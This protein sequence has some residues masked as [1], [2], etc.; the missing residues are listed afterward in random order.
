MPQGAGLDTEPS[1]LLPPFNES[2]IYSIDG[3]FIRNLTPFPRRD[4]VISRPLP[5]YLLRNDGH[6]LDDLDIALVR[7]RT[8]RVSSAS[9]A[10]LRTVPSD[11]AIRDAIG[12]EM[13]HKAGFIN[14]QLPAVR[15]TASHKRGRAAPP[16]CSSN[17]NPI[18]SLS[19]QS[20]LEAIVS[21]RLFETFLTICLP[22]R[23]KVKHNDPQPHAPQSQDTPKRPTRT[24]RST[25]SRPSS[26]SS[27]SPTRPGFPRPSPSRGRGGAPSSPLH[28][29]SS[30]PSSSS[31]ERDYDE[32]PS[33]IS[34]IHPSSTNPSWTSLIPE[35][36]F[37]P[38]ANLSATRFELTIWG[39]RTSGRRPPPS[40]KGKGRDDYAMEGLSGWD[41]LATWPVDLQRLK[42]F[43]PDSTTEYLPPNSLVFSLG[44]TGKLYLG[45]SSNIT[46][47]R[48]PSP[49]H[50]NVSD[51]EIDA[52]GPT[53]IDP[54]MHHRSR[55][56]DVEPNAGVSSVGGVTVKRGA[57]LADTLKLIDANYSVDVE[58][59]SL[60]NLI[61]TVNFMLAGDSTITKA[62]FFNELHF[63]LDEYMSQKSLIGLGVS[64][65]RSTI[66]RRRKQLDERR[67][68][69]RAA[70][71]ILSSNR[72]L[73]AELD[74]L[75]SQQE[76]RF[77]SQEAT[78]Q[79]KRETVVRSLE[80][81]FPIEPT[82]PSTDLL[83]TIVGVP[84]PIPSNPADPAPPFHIPTRPDVNEDT[85]ASALGYAAQ[86]VS[87]LASYLGHILPYPITCAG[88]RSLIK[89]PISNL[90]GPRMFPLF[91]KSVDMYRFEYAVFLLNKDIEKLMTEHNL[92]ALDMRHTLPN[93]KNLLL[94]L[95]TTTNAGEGDSTLQT[96]MQQTGPSR[97]LRSIQTTAGSI[98]VSN[99][100]PAST[101]YGAESPTP[102]RTFFPPITLPGFW[103]TR[104]ARPVSTFVKSTL[105]A[106]SEDVDIPADVGSDSA[107]VRSL[108]LSKVQTGSAVNH[109]QSSSGELDHV[110]RH[111][112]ELSGVQST[113]TG[114]DASEGATVETEGFPESV[115][116]PLDG[117]ADVVIA[118]ASTHEQESTLESLK[119]QSSNWLTTGLSASVGGFGK[120]LRSGGT[121]GLFGGGSPAK[122]NRRGPGRPPTVPKSGPNS[123]G[124]GNS[125]AKETAIRTDLP[126]MDANL[127][128][129]PTSQ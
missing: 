63:Q 56:N 124:H 108:H 61:D 38:G 45:S 1:S 37:S 27:H 33:F 67:T 127:Q 120:H 81:I 19:T 4:R 14:D 15:P 78:L 73:L 20:D 55:H 96:V 62:R 8:R 46:P 64:E 42:P 57:S 79:A 75:A 87:L 60:C 24:T 104:N 111:P 84:L 90:H 123:N 126:L 2:T 109:G 80:C 17:L 32:I 89:D 77:S 114:P 110:D 49:E 125:Q 98:D 105:P 30:F 26:S 41:P 72:D 36:E 68:N 53:V 54:R 82:S 86:V 51:S 40:A 71:A 122:S 29:S 117:L 97:N 12:E 47:E 103:Q 11:G 48:S 65:T 118:S 112:P 121:R 3:I 28:S 91:S 5:S 6:G 21:S 128:S 119:E 106:M 22:P 58:L 129:I 102:R 35:D 93:L 115:P 13:L 94:A 59:R 43:P 95:T 10:T 66:Q 44:A 76:V 99:P 85:T 52:L 9:T 23:T 16:L 88:S 74:L 113:D 25:I 34:S 31:S 50:Q 83:F 116:P 92:Q 7:H 107:T 39:R 101:S 69:L 100:V 18:P 70:Q